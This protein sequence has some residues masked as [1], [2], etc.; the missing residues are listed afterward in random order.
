MPNPPAIT[1]WGDEGKP[2]NT[3]H[4]QSSTLTV[5]HAQVHIRKPGAAMHYMLH[6]CKTE[7]LH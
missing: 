5:T 4:M 6:H 3:K 2:V 1:F 7:F